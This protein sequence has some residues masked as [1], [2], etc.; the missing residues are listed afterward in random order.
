VYIRQETKIVNV[1]HILLT[2]KTKT[3]VYNSVY[4]QMRAKQRKAKH[5]RDIAR[6]R[7]RCAC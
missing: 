2:S 6:C 1:Q 3:S 5:V 7:P 4:I